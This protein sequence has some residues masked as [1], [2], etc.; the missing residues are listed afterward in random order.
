VVS[1]NPALQSPK[2][3]MKNLLKIVQM[4]QMRF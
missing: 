2:G 1:M 3:S 4:T